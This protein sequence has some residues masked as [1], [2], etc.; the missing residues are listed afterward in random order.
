M[1]ENRI[2]P[3]RGQEMGVIQSAANQVRKRVKQAAWVA[4]GTMA[5]SGAVAGLAGW[6]LWKRGMGKREDVRGKVV[7]ITGASRGLGL[8]MAREFAQSGARLA[9]CAREQSELDWARQELSRMGADVLAVQCDVGVHD[10]VQRMVREVR[11]RYGRID[12]LVNNA[13]I[14]TVGPMESQS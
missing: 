8:Q 5:A 7:L 1:R 13:G 2:R 4:A 9:I 11:E 6:M 3:S 10:D 12:I 14:I